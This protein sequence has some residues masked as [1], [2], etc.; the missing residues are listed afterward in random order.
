MPRRHGQRGRAG[1]SGR[2]R[3]ADR[4]AEAR[5]RAGSCTAPAARRSPPTH[6][7]SRRCSPSWAATAARPRIPR[8]EVDRRRQGFRQ[9]VGHR[10]AVGQRHRRGAEKGREERREERREGQA[11]KQAAKPPAK[12]DEP[13][14][15]AAS[16]RTRKTAKPAE[17]PK[18]PKKDEKKEEPK[19]PAKPKL[20]EPA[21]KLIFGKRDKDLLYVRREHG[22]DE[23]RL[24]GARIAAGQAH[25]RPAR[26]PRPDA[27]VVHCRTRRPS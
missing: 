13:K 4:A 1:H 26:L 14:D 18:E 19:E 25:P 5:P 21:A 24:R 10:D 12:K 20:K 17:R 16:R 22:R 15:K 27:A 9:A 11:R 6:R 8:P 2:H 7:R 3:P 23:G